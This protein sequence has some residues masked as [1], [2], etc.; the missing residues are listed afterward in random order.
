MTI[1]HARLI[2]DAGAGIP[3]AQERFLAVHAPIWRRVAGKTLHRDYRT[4]ERGDAQQTAA[5]AFLDA[6][7]ACANPAGFAGYAA[8]AAYRDCLHE[9]R[10]YRNGWVVPCGTEPACV[11]DADEPA[12]ECAC[13][14]DAAEPTLRAEETAQ[15]RAAIERLDAPLRDVLRLRYPLDG[16]E[17]LT[18]QQVA[19]ALGISQPA[20][21]HRERRALAL[22]R[23][24][25]VR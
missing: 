9:R 25:M 7:R 13:A 17:P 3:A 21:L 24:E 15:L 14:P 12:E 20:V 18:Q 23:A 8:T 19:A 22:L 16:G 11:I 4:W 10:L 6:A 2:A 1:L 5:L